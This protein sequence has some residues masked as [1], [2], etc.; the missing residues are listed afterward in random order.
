MILCN[1]AVL[2]CLFLRSLYNL[3]ALFLL[4]FSIK[5]FAILRFTFAVF[6]VLSIVYVRWED[7]MVSSAPCL[8]GRKQLCNP[9]SPFL[10]LN[11]PFFLR[12]FI[13]CFNDILACSFKNELTS[14]LD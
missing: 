10:A 14:H 8:L 4:H 12:A 13:F 1:I 6:I 7:E 2:P 5:I 9:M 3:R 11:I